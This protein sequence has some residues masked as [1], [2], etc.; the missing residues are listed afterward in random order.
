M[1]G[2]RVTLEEAK[3]RVLYVR[4]HV[5]DQIPGKY[6]KGFDLE[7]T[8]PGIWEAKIAEESMTQDQ[9]RDFQRAV[10]ARG[11]IF[12]IIWTRYEENRT[13]RRET[14]FQPKKEK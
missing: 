1:H 14:I 4:C 5:S 10:L 2:N 9:R 6:S 7:E 13:K 8:E 12:K 11:D 3:G